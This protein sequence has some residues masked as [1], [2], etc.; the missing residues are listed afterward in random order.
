MLNFTVADLAQTTLAT[1]AF[2]LFLLPSGYLLALASNLFGMRTRSAAEKTVLSAAYSIAVTPILAVLVI[3]VFSYQVA[4]PMFLLFALIAIATIVRQLPLPA[5]Y[6][7]R[8][9]RSTWIAFGMMLAW[10]VLVQVSLA[11]LQIGHRLYVNYVAYDHSVRV[12]FVEA[13]ARTGV[14]PLNPFYGLGKAPIL[15]YYYYWYAVC[16]L[17]MR[18]VGLSAKACLNA[19]VFW[20]GLGLASLIPLFLK[21]VLDET[22]DLRK[23]SVLGI[24]LLAVTGLDLIPYFFVAFKFHLWLGDME[25]WETDQVSSWLGS[26]VWVP[27][28]VAALTAC[29]AGLLA[30][31]WIDEESAPRQR[32]WAAVIAGLAFASAAGLSV[33][34]TFAFA[35]SAIFWTLAVLAQKRVK[36]FATYL[37]AGALS[38]LLSWQYL[39]DLLNRGSDAG[40]MAGAAG[41]SERFASL[42]LRAAPMAA[43]LLVRL[44][45]QSPLLV[46]FLALLVLLVVYFFEFGFFALVLWLCLRRDMRRATPLSQPRRMTW[47]MFVVCMVTMSVLQS[48]ATGS[49]DLG[50]R[51]ILVAQFVL[52]VWSA[53]I[54]YQVFSG[55]GAVQENGLRVRRWFKIAMVFT[56]VLGVGGTAWQF[57]LLRGYPPMVDTGKMPRSESFLGTEGFGGRTYWMRQGFER[58]NALT[59]SDAVVQYNP[60]GNDRYE[61][62]LYSTRQAAMGMQDCG[63]AFGGDPKRCAQ[64]LP[65]IASL[66][67]VPDTVREWNLDGVCDQFH[68]NLLVAADSDPVWQDRDGWVWTR[69]ALFA[70][71]SFRAIPCG[72]A[73]KSR[74]SP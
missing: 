21:Y 49:N 16:A 14:P 11:D 67:N 60:V 37:A 68:M 12:P 23:K 40:G 53:P 24:A 30:L 31:S 26:L 29:M 25:W 33:Y 47:M 74:S 42:A 19:S 58:L 71:P 43:P 65:F 51:G 63:S 38:A 20:S 9:P 6:L 28:H 61:A 10:F 41:A 15:R 70:N 44:G 73:S 59:S 8:I 1:F 64:A 50:F 48:A 32:V 54:L 3:R 2:A 55:N 57:V 22:K 7:S 36:T 27:H 69:P 18:L 5:G 66:F 39:S 34:V 45:V 56:L 46:Y 35:L 72:T 13:A 52:L 17:P 4:L 62:N